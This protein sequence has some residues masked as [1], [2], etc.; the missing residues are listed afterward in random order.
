VT[1]NFP[2]EFFV[3]REL[4]VEVVNEAPVTQR[5]TLAGSRFEVP[6]DVFTEFELAL[7]EKCETAFADAIS[8]ADGFVFRVGP[9][10]AER[11]Q[12]FGFLFEAR[13]KMRLDAC[14][15]VFDQC[16]R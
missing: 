3:A 10:S 13:K 16:F 4:H 6:V 12:R 7:A 2:G 8:G 14:A 15:Q 5:S 1:I 11:A 9:A